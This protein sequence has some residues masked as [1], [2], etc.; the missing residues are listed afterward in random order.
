FGY[1]AGP[2]YD[3]TTGLGTP[4]GTLLARAMTAVAHS[5][6]RFG[7]SVAQLVNPAGQGGW[8]SGASQALLVPSMS[9][10]R[11]SV[12]FHSGASTIGLSSR[13]SGAYAWTSQLAQQSLQP[14]FDARLVRLFDKQAQGGV[15]QAQ[16]NSG[17]V[18]SVSMNSS[19]GQAIQ[20][21]ITSPFGF[22]DFL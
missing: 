15:V 17:D 7:S 12:Q 11:A 1:Q 21:A 6:M 4:N 13:A 3:L 19:P 5:Q 20:G 14:D 9:A 18:L 16:A 2:G 8:T 10:V 22:A